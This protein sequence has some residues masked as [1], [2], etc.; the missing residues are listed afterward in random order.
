MSMI[1]KFVRPIPNTGKRVTVD[2]ELKP[3]YSTE[4]DRDEFI[5]VLS[6]QG[7]RYTGT[8]YKN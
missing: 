2:I 1:L 3:E 4:E 7:Y 5:E 6:N 8:V